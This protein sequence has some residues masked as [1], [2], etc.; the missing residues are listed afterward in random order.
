MARKK[1]TK[2]QKKKRPVK[3]Q[4]S[5]FNQSNKLILISAIV[6]VFVFIIL[7]VI[8]SYKTKTFKPDYFEA[9][10]YFA[11]E[12]GQGLIAETRIIPYSDDPEKRCRDLVNELIKGPGGTLIATMPK[13]TELKD[14]DIDAAGVAFLDFNT[15]L[16]QNHTGGTTGEMFT[17]YSIVNSL[18]KNIPEILMVQFMVDGKDIETLAGHINLKYPMVPKDD[19]I[20]IN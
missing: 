8:L 14:V 15:L 19:L 16:Q 6:T 3:G 18:T 9:T 5:F 13:G 7:L 1:V 20:K 11:D 10:L 2:K 17:V 12:T 4:T